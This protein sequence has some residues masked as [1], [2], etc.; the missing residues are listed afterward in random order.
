[1]YANAKLKARINKLGFSQAELARHVNLAIE[2]LTGTMGSVTDADVRRWLRGDTKWPQDRIRLCIEE[3]LQ[4]SAE[5]LGFTPRR[6]RSTTA[7][8]EDGPVHRRTFCTATSGA[9]LATVIGPNGSRLGTSDAARLQAEYEKILQEDWLIG[10]ARSVENRAAAL[11]LRIKSALTMGT[12]SARVRKRLH[13]I[14][15]DSSS[16]AAFAAIDAKSA[17]R[18]RVH[19]ER[20]VTFAGLSGDSETQYHVW[21]H[22]AM[23]ACQREDFT[24]GAAAAEVMKASSIARRD[25]LYAS[26]GHMRNARALA[27]MDQRSDTLRALR[28]AEKAFERASGGDRPAWLNF[29]DQSEVDGLV[30]S[31]WFALGNF[32]RAEAGFHRTLAG[33]RADMVRNRALYSAHLALSQAYQGELELA[34]HTGETAYRL[35]EG[36]GSKRTSDMLSKVRKVLT[37]SGSKTTEVTDWIE[38]SRQWS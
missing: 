14:A 1:M 21:N 30:A 20:A 34:C 32:D 7:S 35:T 27:K 3:V 18:A 6:K 15:A 2:R 24:E 29:Y 13:C 23:T 16:S 25:P 11:S 31:I 4:A 9:A 19:L 38:R 10:G 17:K 33:I 26:L 28:T 5:D 22:L 37:I 36:S 12:T 8:P